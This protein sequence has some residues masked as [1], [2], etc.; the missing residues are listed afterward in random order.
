MLFACFALVVVVVVVV[1]NLF[2][3]KP[4][5]ENYSVFLNFQFSFVIQ[6]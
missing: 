2:S 6:R 4:M 3:I 5:F 1:L